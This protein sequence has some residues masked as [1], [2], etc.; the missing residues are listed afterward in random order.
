M[1]DSEKIYSDVTNTIL[2][3]YGKTMTWEIKAGLMGRPSLDAAAYL[4]RATDLPL[5]PEQLIEKMEVLLE[6][7]FR[8][9][10]EMPGILKLVQHLARFNIPIAE[11]LLCSSLLW[12]RD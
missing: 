4:I 8:S 9:V 2:K 10:K 3:P 7:C 5:S 6:G 11:S 12:M 1:I